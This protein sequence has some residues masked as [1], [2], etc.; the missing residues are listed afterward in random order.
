MQRF[1]E[2][3]EGRSLLSALPVLPPVTIVGYRGVPI[4]TRP[5]RPG[6]T[7]SAGEKITLFVKVVDPG[8]SY[9][10]PV[11]LAVRQY[12]SSDPAASLLPGD[13]LDATG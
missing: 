2:C 6:T 4:V 13:V 5:N 7:F 3:L 1:I 11:N 8:H 12:A 10:S 9:E